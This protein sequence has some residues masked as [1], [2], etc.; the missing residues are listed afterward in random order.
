MSVATAT[1]TASEIISTVTGGPTELKVHP[2]PGAPLGAVIELPEG[3]KDPSK[4][5]DKD[6]ETLKKALQTYLVVVIKDQAE[7]APES[8]Y[9]LTKRFDPT[10]AG[11]Y[12]H[13]KEFRN[14][15]SVLRKDGVSVP[16]VPQVQ[17]LGQGEM[18]NHCGLDKFT[19]THPTHNT[20]HKNVLSK[21]EQD[22]GYTRYYRWHIDAALYGLSPPV[23]T[24][25]LG[26][27]VPPAT[28]RQRI[29]YEDTGEEFEVSQAATAFVSGANAFDLLSEE[30]KKLALETTV[31]YPP[32]PFIY[33]S[34]ARATSDGLTMV[35][36]GKE[37]PFDQ[38]PEWEESKIKRLPLVWTNPVTG[39]HHLQTAACAAGSLVRSN[40][41]RLGLE[42]TRKELQRLM[43]PA[44]SPKH[45]YA[46]E[47]QQGDLVIFYNR[48]VWHSVTGQF[49]PGETRLMHQCN[50]SSGLDPVCNK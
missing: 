35:S 30:D 46:H 20:F 5:G 15:K 3:V 42:E 21:E 48:G 50:V 19:L 23:A 29:R 44:I 32:H 17:I 2:L 47:W 45:V 33:I 39:K 31:E 24:T 36:E 43:R 41:E 8:Q 49:A 6:F 11:N 27:H 16:T 38:L 7:L 28:K 12:G 14:E 25:L 18:T 9:E 26:I 13:S 37:L 1:A 22:A 4:L 34:D 40:G 10:C